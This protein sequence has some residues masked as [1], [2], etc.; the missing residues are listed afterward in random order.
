[1]SN[2]PS[3]TTPAQRTARRPAPSGCVGDLF[4]LCGLDWQSKSQFRGD[5]GGQHRQARTTKPSADGG[6]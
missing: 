6:K 1:M 2:D 5:T 3:R 4:A